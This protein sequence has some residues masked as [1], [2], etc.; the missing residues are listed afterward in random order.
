MPAATVKMARRRLAT[1]EPIAGMRRPPSRM[2]RN[3]KPNG[4]A[5]EPAH[6][7]KYDEHDRQGVEESHTPTDIERPDAQ[8]LARREAQAIDAPR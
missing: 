7:H 5:R 6:R 3:V 1:G 8:H 4:E 2:P